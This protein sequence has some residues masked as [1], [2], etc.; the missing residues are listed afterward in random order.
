ME[1]TDCS[2]LLKVAIQFTFH[3]KEMLSDLKQCGGINNETHS[4]H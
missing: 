1:S 2:R 3:G 4:S